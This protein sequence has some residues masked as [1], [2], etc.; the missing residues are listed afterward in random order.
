MGNKTAEYLVLHI[1]WNTHWPKAPLL[2]ISRIYRHKKGNTRM[3][4]YNH[5]IPCS[6]TELTL[7]SPHSRIQHSTL[8]GGTARSGHP[9]H[10]RS[11]WILRRCNSR[12][13]CLT[14][15]HAGL[16]LLRLQLRRSMPNGVDSFGW[17][18][19]TWDISWASV[20]IRMSWHDAER[21]KKHS[22]LSV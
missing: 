19:G 8:E 14:L 18:Y 6:I 16:R 11:G 17:W 5:D 3:E 9:S 15:S 7:H 2:W 10:F 21:E 13:A 20:W 12:L 1:V 4:S 22:S